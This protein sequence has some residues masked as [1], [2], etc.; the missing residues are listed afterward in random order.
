MYSVRLLNEDLKTSKNSQQEK[1]LIDAV[2]DGGQ[3][4]LELMSTQFPI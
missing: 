2:T 1:P 3:F 4:P